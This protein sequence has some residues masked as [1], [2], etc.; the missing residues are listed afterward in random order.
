[1]PDLVVVEG[2]EQV[3]D[4]LPP[5]GPSQTLRGPGK[6]QPVEGIG[7]RASCIGDAGRDLGRQTVRGVGVG[8]LQAVGVKKIDIGP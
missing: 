1:M 3:F 8:G 2:V 6:G 4:V 7:D 5:F